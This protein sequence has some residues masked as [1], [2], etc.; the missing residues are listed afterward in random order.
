MSSQTKINKLAER[1][2]FN[3]DELEQ[4][5]R[6]HSA[7]LDTRNN[8]SFLTKIALSSPYSYFFLPGN[9][10]RRRIE[11]AEDKILP[12][13]FGSCLRA[14][15]SVDLF[16]ECANEGQ[17]MALERFLEG[18]ADCGQRGH[19]EALRVIW[20]CCSY[21]GGFEDE[22]KPE[23]LV[24]LCFRLAFAAGE[25]FVMR[26]NFDDIVLLHMFSSHSHFIYCLDVT[27]SPEAAT[28]AIVAKLASE[29][30]GACIPLGN[31]LRQFGQ[32]GLVQKEQFFQWAELMA[33]QL[34]STLSTFIHNLL[35]HTKYTQH[36]LNFVP[37]QYPNLDQISSIFGGAHC[38]NLFALAATSPMMVGKWHNLYSFEYHGN[39]MNRLQVSLTKL[40]F[41]SPSFSQ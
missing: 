15:I 26:M 20:D 39:S 36:H 23:L 3:N 7:L 18:V 6:C 35:F 40:D 16:V 25:P 27:V 28:N 22:L 14:A 11:L 9:E 29:H 31:S 10:M 38:S 32:K 13:G 5:I 30:D 41:T 34:S 21:L 24:D 12:P 37:F 17:E 33:P 2:P 4:L 1:Y 8:D 19:K